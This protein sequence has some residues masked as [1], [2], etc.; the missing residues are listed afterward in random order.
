MR[1]QCPNC[2][3]VYDRDINTT[4][5]MVWLYENIVGVERTELKQADFKE[6]LMRFF[7]SLRLEAT[8]TSVQR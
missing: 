2:G 1:L 7:E 5:N 6:N 8:D 3:V 4:E